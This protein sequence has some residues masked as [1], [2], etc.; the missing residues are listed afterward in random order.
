[1]NPRVTLIAEAGVNHNGD[2]ALAL[3]LVDAAADAGADAVKFQT[4][5]AKTLASA[6][7]PKADYQKQATGAAEGQLA[8]LKR[9]ELST[10]AHRAAQARAKARNIRFLSAP[11]D[12]GS[13]AFLAGEMK[14]DCLKI[15]SGNLTDAP[16]LLAAGRT[17]LP[18]ILSTGMATLAEVERALGV[19]AFGYAAAKDAKPSRD[20]FARAF[21]SAH[22]RD[23]L[24]G[25]VTLLH[26]TS[27]Y[28][29]RAADANLRAMETLRRA[30]A[31][32][33]GLSDHTPGIVTAIA[34]VALGA[35]IVE[36]HLTLDRAM[37]GPDHAAS[38]DP[39]QFAAL[40]AAVREAASAL[41]D[42]QKRPTAGESKN[43]IAARKSLV[44]RCPI[45]KGEAFTPDNLGTARP[46]DGVPAM[47]Y[48]DW[49]GRAAARDY[50]AGEVLA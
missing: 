50:A 4:F 34:A 19:L 32:P 48:F 25:K 17:G 13:L 16:L 26:C 14:V 12:V 33:V 11:F 29:A 8:M 7:A 23:S 45:A 36:K 15:G 3:K 30:F 28:P 18:V 27:E 46:G 22:G 31:L 37:S 10:E 6:R 42:G 43:K 2:P 20:E 49:L 1:V 39:A 21:T 40:T 24:A 9:L 35:T 38:L 5:H 41:G 44:A 47:E